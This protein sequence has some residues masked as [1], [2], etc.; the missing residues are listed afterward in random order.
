[1]GERGG[2]IA[3]VNGTCQTIKKYSLNVSV[4]TN[5]DGKFSFINFAVFY[6]ERHK[7]FM[8]AVWRPDGKF[9]CCS[10]PAGLKFCVARVLS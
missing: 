3:V 7:N 9:S 6:S 8:P 5:L 4:T 10:Y 2:W 1:M